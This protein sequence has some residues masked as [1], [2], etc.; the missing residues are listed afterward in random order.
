MTC[1]RFDWAAWFALGWCVVF[2][3]FYCGMLIEAR[4]PGARDAIVRAG[5]PFWG[6]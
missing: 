5:A 1:R 2:G 3:V 6:R 4:L